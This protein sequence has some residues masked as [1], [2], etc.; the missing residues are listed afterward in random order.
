MLI[1]PSREKECC[2]PLLYSHFHSGLSTAF[3]AAAVTNL[4]LIDYLEALKLTVYPAS[5]F[6]MLFYIPIRLLFNF[7]DAT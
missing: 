7:R 4:I 5:K 6:E 3:L 1:S 2:P